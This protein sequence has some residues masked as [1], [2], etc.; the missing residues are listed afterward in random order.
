MKRIL[1]LIAAAFMMSVLSVTSVAQSVKDIIGDKT[2]RYIYA[3]A[4]D[5]DAEISF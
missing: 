2:G 3:Q 4:R 5:Q 1:S